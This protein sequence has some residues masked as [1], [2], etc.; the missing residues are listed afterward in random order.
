MDAGGPAGALIVFV[1]EIEDAPCRDDVC[2]TVV[3]PCY[4]PSALSWT[5]SPDDVAGVT[6]LHP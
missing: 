1:L 6:S 2:L 4:L 3:S 5:S